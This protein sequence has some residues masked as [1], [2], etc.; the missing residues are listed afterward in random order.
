M[1]RK[2]IS[3]FDILLFDFLFVF[4][5]ENPQ[6]SDFMKLRRMLISTHMQD[7][8]DT[9]QDV[10]YENFRAQCISQISHQALRDRSKLKRES[11]SSNDASISET[12]RLLIQKDEEV[13]ILYYLFCFFQMKNIRNKCF[14]FL[15]LLF[16]F[17]IRR[18]QDMLVQMQEKLKT[19]TVYDMNKK[20][21]SVIDV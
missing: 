2:C 19:N 15:L 8:K 16:N 4:S 3:P 9:T 21:D 1:V 14:L 6:H 20:N 12:D 18:M 7:L 10:H 11:N 17:Q 5:V 13:C